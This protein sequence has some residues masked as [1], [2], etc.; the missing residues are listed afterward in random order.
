MIQKKDN[1]TVYTFEPVSK[2]LKPHTGQFI[3]IKPYFFGES[4]PFSVLEYDKKTGLIKFAIKKVGRFTKLLQ[5]MAIQSIVYFDGPYGVFTKE[6]QND[7]PKVIFAGGIGIVPFYE[8]IKNFGRTNTILF[9]S[10]KKLE[11]ALYRDNFVKFLGSHYL[12]VIT[13]EQVNDK[14]V[15][16][17][18]LTE[19]IVKKYINKD[20][21]DKGNFFICGSPSFIAGISSILKSIGVPKTRVFVEEFSL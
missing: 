8:L 3:Y 12:E 15:I 5:E 13:K 4:H 17:S 7:I 16:K 6:G 19:D 2:S 9:Y 18:R 21:L 20:Y 10:N 11:D 1:I 14:F